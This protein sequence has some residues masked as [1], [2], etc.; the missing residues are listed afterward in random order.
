VLVHGHG[1]WSIK[2]GSTWAVKSAIISSDLK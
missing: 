2:P 1:T